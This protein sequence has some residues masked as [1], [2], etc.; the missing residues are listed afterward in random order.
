MSLRVKENMRGKIYGGLFFFFVFL[1]SSR[2]GRRRRSVKLCEGDKRYYVFF[3]YNLKVKISLLNCDYDHT[4]VK[5]FV[6][7]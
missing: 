1:F 2:F 3:R 7:P 5:L 6:M 4:R